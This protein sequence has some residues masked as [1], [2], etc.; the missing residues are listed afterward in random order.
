MVDRGGGPCGQGLLPGA[1]TNVASSMLFTPG[2]LSLMFFTTPVRAV[3]HWLVSVHSNRRPTKI[4]RSGLAPP[5]QAEVGPVFQNALPALAH[6][7]A[8]P[9]CTRTSS[10]LAPSTIVSKPWLYHSDVALMPM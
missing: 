3:T 5:A 10:H 6:R 9:L 7:S 1:R 8:K 4:T 2:N